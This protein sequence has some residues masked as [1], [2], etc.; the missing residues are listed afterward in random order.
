MV[1]LCPI[2]PI[3]LENR[4]SPSVWEECPMAFAGEN[5]YKDV[6]RRID[7]NTKLWISRLGSLRTEGKKREKRNREKSDEGELLLYATRA[8]VLTQ[9]LNTNNNNNNTPTTYSMKSGPVWL[10]G[11]QRRRV[12]PSP[13]SETNVVIHSRAPLVQFVFAIHL[14]M[15]VKY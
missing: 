1:E 6:D 2:W 4:R 11:S 13:W 3:Q 10:R 12:S 7:S 14:L 8:V 15:S 9:P 5:D